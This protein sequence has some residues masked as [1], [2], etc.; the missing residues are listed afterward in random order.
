LIQS[1]LVLPPIKSET[2]SISPAYAYSANVNISGGYA[3]LSADKA[4]QPISANPKDNVTEWFSRL[5]LKWGG[6][7]K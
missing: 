4:L 6:E 7:E 3:M 2:S 5:N 1:P